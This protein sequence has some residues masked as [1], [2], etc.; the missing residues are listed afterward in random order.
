MEQQ[1]D[2][3]E[4]A[5]PGPLEGVGVVGRA[6]EVVMPPLPLGRALLAV[7]IECLPRSKHQRLVVGHYLVA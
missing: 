6:D 1:G 3:V 7:Q 5:V 4:S 2:R